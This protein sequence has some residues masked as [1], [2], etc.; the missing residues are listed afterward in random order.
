MRRALHAAAVFFLASCAPAFAE[1]R[2]EA[3]AG[4]IV[5][6]FVELFNSM[7]KTG[8]H[9]VINGPCLS[10]CTLVLD[11]IPRDR[12]C[13]TRRAILGFHAPFNKFGAAAPA[14]FTRVMADAYPAPI[15]KWISRHGGLTDK[16]I[17]LHGRELTA[18][19]PLCRQRK[20]AR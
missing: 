13:V 15:R 18:L 9:V 17:F 20:S 2:I 1:L 16:P 19:Y 11:T 10:A 12:L 5:G 6:D 14:G 8:E 4:G 3:S 7:R